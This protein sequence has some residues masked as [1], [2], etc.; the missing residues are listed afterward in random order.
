MPWD[1]KKNYE[2]YI[3]NLIKNFWTSI[4]WENANLIY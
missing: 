4:S 2:K 1:D 3:Q